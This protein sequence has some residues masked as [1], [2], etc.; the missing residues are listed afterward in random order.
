MK[1]TAKLNS[2]PSGIYSVI[3]EKFCADGSSVKTLEKVLKGG[4]KMVQLR[5][6]EY[7]KGR[8]LKM[9]FEFRKLTDKYKALLIINDHIDIALICKADGVHLG[10]DDIPCKEA[11][12]LA[13]GLIIGVSTHNMKEALQA[14]KDGADYINIGPIFETKTKENLMAPLGI[15]TLKK[16]SK[17]INIPYTVMGGIKE[18][19]IPQLAK[20]G[21][22]RIAMVTEITRADNIT[23]KVKSLQGII[24]NF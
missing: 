19:H 16:I 8:I 5:E 11:K 23:A 6:K 14:Q 15:E 3:T 9:A 22:K 21:A 17:K 13:P 10:Q 7:H 12:K 1:N 2:W 4:A 20:A 18:H 24:K